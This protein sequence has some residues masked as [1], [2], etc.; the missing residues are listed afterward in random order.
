MR[1]DA[2]PTRIGVSDGYLTV[3]FGGPHFHI[4]IGETNG[5]SK[6]PTP[7]DVARQRRTARAELYR[8]RRPACL[9]MS[10]GLRLYNGN[11]DQQIT[12]FLPNPFFDRQNDRVEREPVWERLVLWDKLRARWFGLTNQD[13]VDG[14]ASRHQSA[15]EQ[16]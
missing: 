6:N 11:G 8:T 9:P 12:V 5:F 15:E 4:C 10:W 16:A 14:S 2:A 7:P 1:A 13:P 3:D